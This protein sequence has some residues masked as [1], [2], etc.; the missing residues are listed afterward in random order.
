VDFRS[1]G[2]ADLPGSRAG[3]PFPLRWSLRPLGFALAGIVAFIVAVVVVVGVTTDFLWFRAIGYT[4]VFDV[5][6]GAKWAMFGITGGFL[7]LATGLNA[8]LARRL[9]PAQAALPGQPGLNRYRLAVDL[10]WGRLLAGAL[11]V[12]GVIGGLAGAGSWRTW[13]QFANRTSFGARDPQFHL[14]ISFFVFVLPFLRLVLDYLF[15]A[16]LLS[17]VAAA[18]VHY[19]YGGLRFRPGD[20]QATDGARAHLFILFGLFVLLKAIAYWLD[21]YGIDTSAHA[22]V[23]TGASYSDVNA[24]LPAKTVLSAIAL[25]CALLFF[26]GAARRGAMLP[27]VGFCLLVLSAILVGG[28]YPAVIEQFVVKPNELARE[29]PY[30]HREIDGTRTAYGLDGVETSTYPVS[31]AASPGSARHLDAQVA[32]LPDLRTMD[33]AVLSRTF[34]Q[35]QQVKSFYRFG[36][37][38]D[39]DRYQL[40]GDGP[41]PQDVL[42]GVRD[43]AGPPPGQASWVNTHLV[44]THGFGVVAASAGSAQ[45]NGDP[46]FVESDIPPGGLLGPYQPRVYFGPQERT[47]AIVGARRGSAPVEFDYPAEGSAQQHDTTYGGGGGVPVGS[48]GSRLLYAIKFGDPNILLSGAVNRDSRLLYV[49]SPLARVAK[50]APFLTLDGDVYPVVAHG[51]ILWVADG[52]TTTDSYPYSARY[53]ATGA[54]DGNAA[55]VGPGA[56]EINYIRNSVKAVVNAYTGQVTLYQWNTADPVLRTWMKAFPGLIRPRSAIP[57]YLLAHLRYPQ[58]LFDVQRQVLASYHVQ[59]A[60]AFYGGQDFWSVPNG[61]EGGGTEPDPQ[62]PAYLTMTVPGSQGPEFSLASSFTQ[63]G[64]P[65]MAGYLA[66]DS[67]PDSP[68]YGTIR[69]LDLPQNTAL[70]GPQQVQNTFESYPA[71]SAELTLLRRGGSKV[72]LG[73]LISLPVGTGFLYVEPMYVAASAQGNAGSY[74]TLQDVLASYGGSVGFGKTLQAALDQVFSGLASAAAPA[75]APAAT[76]GGS[77]RPAGNADAAVR[78]DIAQAERYYSAAQTALKNGDFTAYG[79]DMAAMKKALDAAQQAASTR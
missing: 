36:N 61:P 72:I 10:N 25:L 22:V 28:V 70:P 53:D 11:A 32:A 33:P 30:L 2:S 20:S 43:M 29:A 6:Y 63:Q 54:D 73:N 45:A 4:G 14:D 8:V 35:L 17:L 64:R 42:I 59:S 46:S 66:V 48:V 52:Y 44:Y 41:T 47:Y 3:I 55:P 1:R 24:V 21:R 79:Q 40:P 19:L 39:V 12:I 57:S 26:A 77:S 51:Q 65:N 9:R 27:A 67:N 31:A 16:V 60:T 37:A 5:T 58:D 7:A 15:V 38:L 13:L 74:P 50:V 71:A 78:S 68:G 75:A 76:P 49:R 56:G 69:L 62:P 23:A 18:A 34:Q